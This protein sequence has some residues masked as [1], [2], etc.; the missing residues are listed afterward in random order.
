MTKIKYM[1]NYLFNIN[2]INIKY[3]YIY[4]KVT[5]YEQCPLLKFMKKMST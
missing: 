3:I 5:E 2:Y 4:G 1:V